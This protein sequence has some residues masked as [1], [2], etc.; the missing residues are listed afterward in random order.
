MLVLQQSQIGLH[1]TMER[2]LNLL[3]PL[4]AAS[5]VNAQ[6]PPLIP[7][8]QDGNEPFALPRNVK[9]PT[10]AM[11]NGKNRREVTSWLSRARRILIMSGVPVHSAQAVHYISS[12]LSENALKWYEMTA[13][14]VSLDQRHHAGFISFDAFAL[15]MTAALG[16]HFPAEKARDRLTVFKQRG[17]VTDY[18]SEF[19]RILADIP[20]MDIGTTRYFY[21][22]GLKDKLREMITGK[23]DELATWDVIHLVACRHDQLSSIARPYSSSSSSHHTPM[24]LTNVNVTKEKSKPQPARPASKPRPPLTQ[25]E[26]A[27]LTEQGGCFY[28]RKLGHMVSECPEKKKH[29]AYLA[30]KN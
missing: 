16:E 24:D 2:F 5:A 23:F 13:A 18:G 21:L 15:A 14:T 4:L 28:C 22:R 26:R 27:T 3:Q 10:I 17:P 29:D 9:L 7:A 25:A 12:F 1:N 11:F 8:N 30:R 19:Q 20:D 6:A